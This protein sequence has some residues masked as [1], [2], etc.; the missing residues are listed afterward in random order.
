VHTVIRTTVYAAMVLLTSVSIWA[1][2]ASLRVSVL[3]EPEVAIPL[4]TGGTWACAVVALGIAVALGL[5]LFAL[6]L[7][8]LDEN[9]RLNGAG[10]FGFAVILLLSVAF[11]ADVLYR[12]ADKDFYPRQAMT[13]TAA[14]YMAHLDRIAADAAS[15]DAVAAVDKARRLLQSAA[16]QDMD[17]V[18]ATEQAVRTALAEAGIE[19]PPA[20]TRVD[21]PLFAMLAHLAKVQGLGVQDWFL[22]L[23]ALFLDL[24]DLIAYRL[25]PARR[26]AEPLPRRP[27]RPQPEPEHVEDPMP[28]EGAEHPAP[29]EKRPPKP[30]DPNDLPSGPTR[31]ITPMHTHRRRKGPIAFR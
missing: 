22:L 3:P 13:Q 27:Q 11:N 1:N 29:A 10:A 6:K 26:L 14:V 30:F 12:V 15:P 25:L 23:I 24:G 2:Y 18:T 20:P 28:W 8:I 7:T 19:P 31:A 5:M 4:P 17:D 16:P 9:R 21:S